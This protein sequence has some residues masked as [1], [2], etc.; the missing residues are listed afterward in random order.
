[1]TRIPSDFAIVV[2]L[3][4]LRCNEGTGGEAE[5]CREVADWIAATVDDANLRNAARRAGVPL[6][7][8]RRRLAEMNPTGDQ[9]R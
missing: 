8:L 5:A 1:M 3:D 4:W 6:S 7:R 9:N 2:A